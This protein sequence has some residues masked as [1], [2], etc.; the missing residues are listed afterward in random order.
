MLF[1]HTKKAFANENLT[2]LACG[3]LA[4][5]ISPANAQNSAKS[6][7]GVE[8]SKQLNKERRKEEKSQKAIEKA[9]KTAEKEAEAAQAREK[10]LPSHEDHHKLGAHD[11]VDKGFD[12]NTGNSKSPSP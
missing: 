9:D 11:R 3:L 4:M 10:S 5:M 7:A 1:P 2:L 8:S 6:T 12:F